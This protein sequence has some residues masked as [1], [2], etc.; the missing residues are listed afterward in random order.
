M[1]NRH[2]IVLY[3]I[4]IVF[5]CI[6]LYCICVTLLCFVVLYCSVL[7][8]IVLYRRIVSYCIYFV[9]CDVFPV[10][11]EAESPYDFTAFARG[12]LGIAI[13]VILKFVYSQNVYWHSVFTCL[14]C[15]KYDNNKL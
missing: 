9:S 14:K 6:V 1:K 15:F 8:F 13:T 2:L 12:L 3:C 11:I 10:P 5:R 4:C 7:Y